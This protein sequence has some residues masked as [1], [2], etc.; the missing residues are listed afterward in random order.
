MRVG[1][2]GMEGHE[3]RLQPEPAEQQPRGEPQGPAAAAARRS[4]LPSRAASTRADTVSSPNRVHHGPPRGAGAWQEAALVADVFVVGRAAAVVVQ[5]VAIIV[6][7][8]G[9]AVSRNAE[10]GR[11]SRMPSSA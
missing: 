8:I 7:Q 1:Q 4:L 9:T 2:P 6:R 3:G 11:T 10:T 5:T